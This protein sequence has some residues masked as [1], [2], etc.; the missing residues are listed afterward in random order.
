LRDLGLLVQLQ[1]AHVSLCPIETLTRPQSPVWEALASLLP[2]DEAKSWTLVLHEQ[3]QGDKQTGFLQ[4]KQP[5]GRPTLHIQRLTPPLDGGEDTQAAWSQLINYAVTAAGDRGIQRIFS[6]AGNGSPER[7]VLSAAGFSLY[8][9]EDIYRLDA[10]SYSQAHAP[11]GVRPE[12]S[13]DLVGINRLY[14]EITPRLVQQAETPAG[15]STGWLYEPMD[16]NRGEGFVLEDKVGIAGYGHLLSGLIGHWLRILVHAR[17]YD[18]ASDLVDYGLALLNYYSPLP[19]YCG[20]RE[21]QGGIRV[22]LEER[23]FQMFSA[24]CRLVRHTMARVKEPAR[25]L[26][27][28]L[29][30][31]VEAPTT[32]VS[33]TKRT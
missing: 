27:P 6:C 29:E 23:G 5:P 4:A 19:V 22:P 8:A 14:G 9:R 18:R 31:R 24:Q 11:N 17:A 3:R 2:F 16:W 32:T 33:P 15:T 10:A 20:V 7:A 21:Y 26:V 12:Q 30:K 28:A 13:V 1:K 25:S